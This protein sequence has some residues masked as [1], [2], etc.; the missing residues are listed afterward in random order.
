M[1]PGV[2]HIA[3]VS[4]TAAVSHTTAVSHTAAVSHS[5]SE[6]ESPG[7]VYIAPVVLIKNQVLFK[8]ISLR[9]NLKSDLRQLENWEC[10]SI[11]SYPLTKPLMRRKS[12]RR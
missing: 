1:K 8:C 2:S 4:H 11:R 3:G 6:S 7:E 12:D 5:S 10:W 9:N